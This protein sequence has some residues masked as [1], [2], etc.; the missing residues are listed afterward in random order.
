M[1]VFW[2]NRYGV[3]KGEKGGGLWV[4]GVNY[5]GEGDIDRIILTLCWDLKRGV[6]AR[7]YGGG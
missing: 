4:G 6:D 2:V 5:E 1:G 3:N 7:G